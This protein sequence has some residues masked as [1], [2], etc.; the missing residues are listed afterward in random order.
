[1]AHPQPSKVIIKGPVKVGVFRRRFKVKLAFHHYNFKLVKDLHVSVQLLPY[2]IL[3][4]YVQVKQHVRMVL[5][6]GYSRLVSKKESRQ[7]RP[8]VSLQ[9]SSF[10]IKSLPA[11]KN[12]P[13]SAYYRVAGTVPPHH[14][15]R[16]LSA[17]F[18]ASVALSH[19]NILGF[20]QH[21]L[22]SESTL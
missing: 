20:V 17:S 12:T 9:H 8:H 7:Y 6:S 21:L 10:Q 3:V 16:R 11:S 19:V 1:M 15:H 22:P 14:S 13:T 2:A 4:E 18:H 5:I